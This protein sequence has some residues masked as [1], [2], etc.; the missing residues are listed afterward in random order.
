MSM[1]TVR[2]IARLWSAK[3]YNRLLGQLLAPRGEASVRLSAELTGANAAAAMLVVRLDELAQVFAPIYSEAIRSL[4]ANQHSDGGW[5]D[6]ITTAI[7]LRALFCGSGQG[8]A[9]DRGLQFLANL[10][11][12]EGIWPA[13]PVRR[14]PADAFASAF[15][16]MQ[17]GDQ[18]RFRE[19]VRFDE[20]V[21]WFNENELALDDPTRK[22]WR[23]AKPRCQAFLSSTLSSANRSAVS[24]SRELAGLFAEN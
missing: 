9:I 4:T 2:H 17:L 12:P 11:R 24:R 15:I 10:Q 16:L 5:A 18:P 6:P 19:A 1:I 22:L 13:E 23:H 14:M 8:P 21:D 3:D 20:A 7:V